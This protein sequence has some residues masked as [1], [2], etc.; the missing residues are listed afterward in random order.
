MG[1]GIEKEVIENG[2]NWGFAFLS[3]L[4]FLAII[5]RFSSEIQHMKNT[6]PND[7]K[8]YGGSYIIFGFIVSIGSYFL[9]IHM[10]F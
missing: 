7:W 8:M 4:L 5:I 6:Y 3:I 1:L 2:I 9:L 10:K